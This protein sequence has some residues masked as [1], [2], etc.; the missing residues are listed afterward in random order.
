[1]IP[2]RSLT[3]DDAALVKALLRLNVAQHDV[4]SLMGCNLGRIAEI[5]RRERFERVAP[6]D[7]ADPAHRDRVAA[8]IEAEHARLRRAFSFILPEPERRAS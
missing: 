1:M 4:A 5:N 6:A 3:E 2:S 7:L 8:L